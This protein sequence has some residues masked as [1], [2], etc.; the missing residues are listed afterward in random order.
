MVTIRPA[1]FWIRLLATVIDT[2]AVTIILAPLLLAIYGRE[3]LDLSH[4]SKGPADFF[5]SYVVPALLTILL[6]ATIGGTPGKLLLGLR[7]VDATSGRKPD[8]LQAT[9]RYLGYFVSIFAIML[10]FLWV[11]FDPRKQGFHDKIAHT[12]V[13]H[14]R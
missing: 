7:V 2:V 6:W 4:A 8:F 11:A 9:V 10:G 12:L 14:A 1:G 5:I 3:Y 13:V